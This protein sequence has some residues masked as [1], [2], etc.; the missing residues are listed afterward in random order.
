[1]TTALCVRRAHTNEPRIADA[2]AALAR[3]LEASTASAVLLFCSGDYDL[4][5]LGPAIAE[6]F[7]APVAACTTAG[8]I[9]AAGFQRGGISG[10]SLRGSDLSMRPLLLSPLALCQ[11]QAVS[12]GRQQAKRAAGRAGLK[13]FGLILVDGSSMWEEFVASALYEA[14]GNVTLV[15]G[16][17]A[18]SQNQPAAAVYHAGRFLKDAAVLALFETNALDF[19]SFAVQHFVPSSKKLVIT[20]ADPDRRVVYEING[21]SAA[22]AYAKALGVA[23]AEL[24]SRHFACSP[25]LLDLGEQ[26]LPRAIRARQP[27][28]SLLMACA[29][30][31]GLV[32]SIADSMDPLA[33][34]EHALDDVARRVP[35]PAALLVFDCVLRRLELET[36]GLDGQVGELLARRGAVGFSGFG[37]QYGPLHTTHTLT[38]IALG[39]AAVGAHA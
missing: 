30:E 22:R 19:A 35:E 39:T 3:E 4:E 9:G 17:A 33:T 28:G 8:Q 12:L 10:M 21:E 13:S 36:R 11:S 2:L 32:V 6:T 38:G 34:L 26:L 25:L 1:M 16:S 27:D 15:G 31:E 20:L 23:E 29:L 7:A 5:R 24:C 18:T 37:E 14:L